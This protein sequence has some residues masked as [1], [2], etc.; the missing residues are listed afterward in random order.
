[1]SDTQEDI[2]EDITEDALLA[3]QELV[4]DTAEEVTEEQ[5]YSDAI[6]SVL[7]GESKSK[8]EAMHSKK[9]KDDEVDEEDEEDEE[10]DEMEE[11]YMKASKSKKN[12]GA[13]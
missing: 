9:K 1:M 12:E 5:S 4:Q 3:D 11:G 10:E 2:I 8:K 6:R 13:H 7:L